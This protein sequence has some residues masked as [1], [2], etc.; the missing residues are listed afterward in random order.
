M[1]TQQEVE[2][3]IREIEDNYKHVLT[4]SVA[5]VAINAPRALEQIAAETRLQT[6]HWMLGTKFKSKLKGVDR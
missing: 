6:L 3:K 1:K 2:T 4:G 5:T